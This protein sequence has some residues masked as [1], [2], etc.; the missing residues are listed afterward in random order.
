[1]LAVVGCSGALW[2]EVRSD[3]PAIVLQNIDAQYVEVVGLVVS[4]PVQKNGY[5]E[6][7]LRPDSLLWRNKKATLDGDLLVR[8]YDWMKEQRAAALLDNK[9]ALKG[10]FRTPSE[11]RILGEF[12]YGRWLRSQDIVGTF[13]S[14]RATDLFVLGKEEPS[15]F[16]RIVRSIRA[17]VQD[18]TE[19]W[20][21]GEEGDIA[22]GC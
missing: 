18:F 11:P 4:K 13:E 15:W 5:V 22:W 16:D 17:E 7:R 9:V 10:T 8:V 1:M 21:G 3:N 14:F 19:N 2:Y 6:W 12:D 20:I